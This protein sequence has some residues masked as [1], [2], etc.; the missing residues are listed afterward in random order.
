MRWMVARKKHKDSRRELQVP[1][2]TSPSMSSTAILLNTMFSPSACSVHDGESH[3]DSQ[4]DTPL[5][6]PKGVDNQAHLGIIQGQTADPEAALK[7]RLQYHEKFYGYEHASTISVVH[8][9][10]IFYLSMSQLDDAEAMFARELRVHQRMRGPADA[11]TLN[12][13]GNLAALY[14]KQGRSS[15]AEAMY[16][17]ALEGYERTLG[18]EH[19]STLGAA[20]D[21]GRLYKMQGRYAEAE[22]MFKRVL[23]GLETS[24][25]PKRTSAPDPLYGSGAAD[26]SLRGA[27]PIPELDQ[28][29][30]ITTVE[31]LGSLYAD[32]GR[33]EDA[34]Q[35][36]R[37]ARQ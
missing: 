12:T 18:P 37:R 27:S 20:R 32:Q 14:E 30:A 35:L 2:S 33:L 36:Y 29:L 7:Q 16:R 34:E 25:N 1:R 5:G 4:P 17:Q 8:E 24:P 3:V 28:L 21:L 22:D 11:P 10:G 23:G 31:A 13:I 9:L 15:D 19:A 6:S 26:R